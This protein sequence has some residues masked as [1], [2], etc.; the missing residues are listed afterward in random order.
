M[1]GDGPITTRGRTVTSCDGP[2]ASCNGAKAGR[3]AGTTLRF[4]G[5]CGPQ[6]LL[7]SRHG[8]GD[9]TALDHRTGIGQNPF[10]Q[11]E[12]EGYADETPCPPARVS[13]LPG[14]PA[15][16]GLGRH[17]NACDTARPMNKPRRPRQAQFAFA[18]SAE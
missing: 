5:R 13:R 4:P 8:W 9:S 11:S 1:T 6:L 17:R 10:P 15:T 18:T 12:G 7:G 2:V 3:S 16:R 14:I